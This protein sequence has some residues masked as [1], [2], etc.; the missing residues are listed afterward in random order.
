MKRNSSSTICSKSRAGKLGAAAR[1][2]DHEKIP[3]K[4]TRIYTDDFNY[5]ADLSS[6]S[7]YPVVLLVHRCIQH[8][9]HKHGY[10]ALW[11]GNLD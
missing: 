8:I 11:S 5:L 4:L 3:T 1:W 2:T 10:R 6:N 9:R 7:G